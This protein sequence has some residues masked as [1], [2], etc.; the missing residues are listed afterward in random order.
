MELAE[1]EHR[2]TY[3]DGFVEGEVLTGPLSHH[4][5]V[6]DIFAIAI[7]RGGPSSSNSPAEP[8]CR[9][10]DGD[11]RQFLRKQHYS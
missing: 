7:A 1:L 5:S 10:A 9:A 4:K 3:V 6:S 11:S 2:H 8:E